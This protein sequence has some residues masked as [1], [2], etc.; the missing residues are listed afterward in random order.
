MQQYKKQLIL[1]RKTTLNAP[2][3]ADGVCR[4]LGTDITDSQSAGVSSAALRRRCVIPARGPAA[5]AAA[6]WQSTIRNQGV[7]F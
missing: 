4:I 1:L 3:L 7:I 2:Q 6:A 5:G